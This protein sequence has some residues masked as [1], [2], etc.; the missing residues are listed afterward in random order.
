MP[1]F[2]L[3]NNS[4][5][6]RITRIELSRIELG[7]HRARR[8]YNETELKNLADSISRFGLLSPLLVR[9]KGNMFELLAGERRLRALKLLGHSHADAIITSAPDLDCALMGLIENLQRE[10]MHFLDTAEACRR[11]L[12]EHGLTQEE[13]AASLG[14]SPSTLANL[15]RLLR[16]DKNVCRC[17]REGRLSERHARALLKL[18]DVR[19]QMDMAR[20]AAREQ[21]SVRQLETLIAQASVSKPQTGKASGIIRDNR[22]VINALQNTVRRLKRI[23]IPAS[24]RV[25]SHED[26]YDIIVTIRTP[27]QAK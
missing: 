26:Y 12:K 25:E 14:K 8:S 18:N 7:S 27:G 16:L 5:E 17:I 21:L 19:L 11:I 3:R 10:D 23:G 9:R 1:A 4:P 22:L 20:Q 6:R 2:S 24:S 13:L 15:L